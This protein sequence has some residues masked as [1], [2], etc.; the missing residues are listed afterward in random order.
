M[1][2]KT[3]LQTMAIVAVSGVALSASKAVW[4]DKTI[5]VTGCIEKDAATSTPIYKVIVTQP[6]GT[7]AIYQLNAPGNATVTNSAG[8]TAKVDGTLTIEKRAGREVKVI[9]VK[10]FEVVADGCRTK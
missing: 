7:S 1:R 6:D 10:T 5:T 8:K 4:Q 9:T 3:V 2:M